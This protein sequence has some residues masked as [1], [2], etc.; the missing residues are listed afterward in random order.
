MPVTFPPSLFHPAFA[1]GC[2]E[3]RLYEYNALKYRI[4][5]GGIVRD[6]TQRIFVEYRA[7]QRCLRA[8]LGGFIASEYYGNHIL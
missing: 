6:L 4:L 5:G 3:V 1:E 8:S 7:F 2:S